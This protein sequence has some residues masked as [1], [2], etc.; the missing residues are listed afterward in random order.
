[1]EKGFPRLDSMLILL[2]IQVE[3]LLTFRHQISLFA[4]RTCNQLLRLEYGFII[5][6]VQSLVF[7]LMI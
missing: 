3:C 2:G 6:H 1:M 5:F 7:T 4:I